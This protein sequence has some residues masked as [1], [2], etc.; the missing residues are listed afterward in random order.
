MLTN[1]SQVLLRNRDLVKDQSV[2]VLNYEGDHLPKELLNTARSVCGLAL[3]YHHH[4]MM[5]PYAAANLT[6]HFGHQLPNDESFDTV[7]VYF[8]KAKALAPYL[9]NLAAK[10]L[11]P[12]GQLI[13]VGENKGGIKSLPKQLPSYF[14]KPFK[15][16]NARHCIV[17]LSELNAAAP[18][19][20][21][22]DWISRYQLDTPQGQV[23][24]C[25]LVGV[26]SEKKLDEGTKLLL[27][28]LP[29]MRG[30]VL[31]FGCGAG[32]IAAALL[33]AQ[34]ELTLECVDINA[35][36]LASCEFTLQANGFNAKIFASDGLAQA[37]GRYDGIISNPP[38]HDGL[39]STTNIA[40]NFVKDSAANLTTGGLFHIVANRHLPY[41]DT[42]AEH[43]GSVDVTAENNKYKIYS[44]VK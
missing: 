12:Q 24:I 32:V 37:A 33:K 3:D 23:T 21:L 11:K 43:F 17:F 41:S 27:E 19:L 36:A 10:H 28:N 6:L 34:P 35:M 22:T 44:N 2:L 31:D 16:D 14:D 4:L 29:K 40:T 26:F 13:V 1:A 5:Q 7:I 15:A 20:K 9:F 30:K 38:F 42:I 18:T 39:A 8:P 25:N